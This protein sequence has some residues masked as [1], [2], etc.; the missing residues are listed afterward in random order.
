MIQRLLKQKCVIATQLL[1]VALYKTMEQLTSA[2]KEVK[3]IFFNTF[4]A[5]GKENSVSLQ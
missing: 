1:E 4:I 3:T 5:S 2:A